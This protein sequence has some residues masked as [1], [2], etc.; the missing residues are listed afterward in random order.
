M[1][2]IKDIPVET[3]KKLYVD[4]CKSSREI[5]K[6]LNVSKETVLKW[7]D[8]SG[9]PRRST[10]EAAMIAN[11][12]LSGFVTVTDNVQSDLSDVI[13]F[14]EEKVEPV[15]YTYT[16][17]DVITVPLGID[18][19]DGSKSDSVVTVSI[20]DLHLSHEGHLPDT[21]WSTIENLCK[22]L[23]T[24]SRVGEIK[25]LNIVW[26]GDIMS[27]TNVYK[28]QHLQNIVQR[29]HFQ[30][31]LAERV[32]RKTNEKISGIVPVYKNYLIHGNHECQEQNYTLYLRKAMGKNTIYSSR[33]LIL[34]IGA[35]IGHC[36]TLFTHG[37]GSSAYFPV[38]YEMVREI[39]KVISE[40]RNAGIPIEH[41]SLGHTH[42]LTSAIDFG[43]FYVHVNGGFQRWEYTISQRPAGVI[44]FVYSK[45]GCTAIPVRPS[46]SVEYSERSDP[47]LEYKNMRY[48]A[49]LL[50]EHLRLYE[51]PDR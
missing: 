46:S 39:W 47:S 34:D 31:F 48:Y 40:N 15:R 51:I 49:E 16:P 28:T 27:G 3:L 12:R 8:K 23:S 22:V 33:S 14:L 11:S 45:N 35:P 36:N 32:L 9:I 44:V 41:V 5:A 17:T 18:A 24:L 30:V 10:S 6:I 1:S 20:S 7:L 2:N 26:N 43:G 21:Y 19:L 4:E 38:S 42:W 25:R 29:G 13:G 37:A 50:E